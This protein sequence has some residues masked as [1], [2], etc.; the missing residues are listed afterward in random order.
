MV[1]DFL[2]EAAVLV[3]VFGFLDQFVRGGGV[4]PAYAVVVLCLSIFLMA[5]G[6]AMERVRRK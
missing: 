5:V 2:R 1:A 6:V 3:M 4:R